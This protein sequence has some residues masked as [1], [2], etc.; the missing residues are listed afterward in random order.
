MD[1]SVKKI[2]DL[3]KNTDLEELMKIADKICRH[4]YGD[5]VYV[6]GLVEFSNYCNRDCLYCGIRK[7]ND[8]VHRYRLDTDEI[9]NIVLQ[10]FNRGFKTFVL[11][12]GEDGYYSIKKLATIVSTIVEKTNGE[13]AITLSCGIF[14]RDQYKELK[15]AGANRYLI[16]FE[17]SDKDLHQYLR[18]GISLERRLKALYDLKDLGYEV[19]SGFMVGLPGETED[20]RINNALL[21]KKLELDMIGLGP[22]IP[23]PDTPLRESKKE[24]LALTLRATALVRM[25]L[26]ESNI[27]ATTATGTIDK[28]GRE[29]ALKAG[30]NV[31]MVNITPTDFKKDYLLY[32]DKICLDEDG[33]K[34]L[35]CIGSKIKSIDKY[36]TMERGNS[37]SWEKRHAG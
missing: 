21:C 16:R 14:S 11:Q 12:S 32:P 4:N 29:K 26:P 5:K 28:K 33:L 2:I 31:I 20:I 25:L 18:N 8:K 3:Y 35:N 22:F 27:P 10:G 9:L 36:L 19:G 23:H 1:D 13:A 15:K 37:K 34:C 17:T 30:A 7:S 24:S 6:R